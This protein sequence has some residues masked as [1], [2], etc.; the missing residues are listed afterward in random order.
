MPISLP[1]PPP[2]PSGKGLRL[3]RYK[4]LFS[5]PAIERVPELQFQRPEP[6][7]ELARADAAKR[8]IATGDAVT[9]SHNGT[10]VQLR[11]RVSRELRDGV[12]RIA[13]E[14]AGDLGGMVEV[15]K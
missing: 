15:A 2:A 12:V 3:V 6:E 4:P 7:V 10:S 11:A 1:Q 13:A 8:R 9:V 5:G 14:H